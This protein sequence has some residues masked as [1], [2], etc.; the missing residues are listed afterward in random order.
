MPDLMTPGEHRH[1]SAVVCFFFFVSFLFALFFAF[2]MAALL[3]FSFLLTIL[4]SS[5][6]PLCTHQRCY[7]YG[8]HH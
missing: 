4:A 2:Q 5:C 6:H 7:S 3:L 1:S 8:C